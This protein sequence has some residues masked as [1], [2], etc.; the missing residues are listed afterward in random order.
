MK[1]SQI[2]RIFAR[3]RSPEKNTT[4]T[5]FS[6]SSRSP[7]SITFPQACCLRNMFP[8]VARKTTRSK[9]AI[10]AWE[11][12]PATKPSR[13]ASWTLLIRGASIVPSSRRPPGWERPW[14]RLWA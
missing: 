7:G 4:N 11:M 1:A 5:H 2:L 6:T 10:L 14:R 9:G 12:R 3:A 8:R 13:D